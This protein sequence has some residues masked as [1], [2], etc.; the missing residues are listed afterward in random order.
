MRVNRP[1]T[2]PINRYPFTPGAYPGI[3]P[4]FSFFLS[5]E[6][7]I[8]LKPSKVDRFLAERNLPPLNSRY[9]ILAYGSNACPGQLVAKS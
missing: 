8:R 1:R 4:K 7:I 2:I 3:R 6:G 5:S 9:A